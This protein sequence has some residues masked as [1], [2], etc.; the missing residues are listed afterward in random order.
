M[1]LGDGEWI[2]PADLPGQ[3]LNDEEFGT[4]DDL[5]KAIELYEKSHIERTLNKAGA[6]KCTLP[7]SWG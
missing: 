6:R 1:I 3:R 4:E 2:K 5:A 7:S